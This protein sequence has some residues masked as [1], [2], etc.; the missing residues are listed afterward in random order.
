MDRLKGWLVSRPIYITPVMEYYVGMLHIQTKMTSQGQVSV[1]AAIRQLLALTPGSTLVWTQEEGRV[2][3]HRA[4]RHSTSEVHQALFA[5]VAPET[6]PKTLAELKQGVRQHMK[7][8]H[9]RG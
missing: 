3:V 2:T 7:N 5:E 8:R 6:A 4:V 1:P 9:A